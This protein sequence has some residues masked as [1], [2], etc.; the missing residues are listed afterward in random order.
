MTLTNCSCGVSDLPLSLVSKGCMFI[1]YS[2]VIKQFVLP[3]NGCMYVHAYI[4][5]GLLQS[6][7]GGG[8]GKLCR[9]A[10]VKDLVCSAE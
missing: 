5:Q 2:T 4:C 10:T 3:P 9:D 1:T 6:W 7:N 8:G